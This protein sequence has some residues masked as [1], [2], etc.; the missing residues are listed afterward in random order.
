MLDLVGLLAR[1]SQREEALRLLEGLASRS[2]GAELRRVRA[3]EFR[4]SPGFRRAWR[5]LRAALQR[6]EETLI[7]EPA[8][9]RRLRA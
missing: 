8:P 5:W 6:S 4:L 7:P 9:P 1:T 2:S 3:A